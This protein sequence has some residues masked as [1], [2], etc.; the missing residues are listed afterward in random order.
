MKKRTS[1]KETV[2]I[3]RCGGDTAQGAAEAPGATGN[4]A[5]RKTTEEALRRE[6]DFLNRVMDTTPSGVVRVNR[7]GRVTYANRRAEEILG[8]TTSESKPRTY[9]DPRWNITDADGR[10][11]PRE[12][13]PFQVVRRT[14]RPVSGIRHAI[15]WPGGRR[16]LLSI[17]AAP[18]LDEG[19]GFDGMVAAMED[20]T[21]QHRREME[22]KFLSEQFAV[23]VQ[24]TTDGFWR[25]DEAGRLRDVNEAYCRMSGYSRS[26]LLEMT[27]MDLEA[28]ETEGETRQRMRKLVGEGADHFETCHRHK[29]GGTFYLEVSA[30]YWAEERQF[31]GFLR[32]I[33]ERKRAEVALRENE[34]RLRDALDAVSDGIWDLN[35]RTG[36]A[37]LNSR[38][39][40]MFG[41]PPDEPPPDS[42]GAFARVHPDDLP[43][44]QAALQNHVT[45]KAP[46][47][48][49]EFRVCR[50]DGRVR[51]LLGRGR[52]IEWDANGVPLRLIGTNTDVT[53]R[54]ESEA[55]LRAAL[56]AARRREIETRGLLDA[57]RAILE[58]DSFAEAARR[59]FDACREA[60]GGVS[61]YVAL[62]TE[63]GEENEVLFVESGGRP[64]DVDPDLPMP[65]R[66]LRAEACARREPVFDNDFMNSEWVR[67]MPEGHVRMEN[68]LFAPLILDGAVHGVMGLANKPGDFTPEDA[69][70]AGA[71][72]DMAAIALRRVRFE[73][74][75]RNSEAKYRAYVDHSPL[76]ILIADEAG[77]YVDVN[78]AAT[79]LFGYTREELLGM[80][81]TDLL[82]T[83]PGE[84][85]RTDFRRLKETGFIRVEKV[86]RRK[87][88]AR[89]DVYLEGVPLG[90]GRY[91]GFCSD[92]SDRKAAERALKKSEARVR[93]KL[94][95][96][97]TPEGELGDLDLADVLDVDAVQSLMDDFHR[98][99][100]IGVAIIDLSGKVLVATGWQEICTKF[101]RSHPET[102]AN[103]KESDL[104][105]SQ[106]IAADSFK[107]Y[108]C[109]NHMWD[110]ATPIMVGDRHLGNLFLGQ[111]FFEDEVPDYAVF[112][113]Q[114]RRY[115]F[116]EAAYIAALD[117][118]PRWSRER[119]H[120][121]MTFYAKFAGMVSSLSHGNIRLARTLS[122]RD[123]LLRDLRESEAKS[124]AIVD[125][126]DLG[127]ALIDPDMRVVEVNRRMREWFPEVA[128][129]DRPLCYQ[130]I[131]PI[132]RD[133]P[134]D[135]CPV[136]MALAD[137]QA[138]RAEMAADGPEGKR[139]FRVVAS[140]IFD[141][142]GRVTAAI[143]MMEDVTEQLLL[144][145][146]FRQAQKMEAIGQLTGGVAH[147]FNNLLQI[148]NGGTD[149]ALEDTETGH[150]ARESMAEVA[151]AG[152]RAAR[153]V[154]QLLLFSRRQIMRPADLELNAV[155]SDLLKMLGR[156][157]GEHIRIHWIPGSAPGAIHAD[158]GMIEQVLMNL[159]VNARDA[160]PD[161]G[162]LTIE[163]RIADIDADYCAHH[164]W[165]VP[166][167]YALLLVTDTGCGMD[168]ETLDRVFEPFFT[169]KGAG[170]G[171][172][173]GLATVYGIVKQHGG[174]ISGYSEPGVG[175]TFKVYLPSREA[176]AEPAGAE[177][178]R[179]GADGG[180]ET[181]LL[182]EDDEMVRK[183]ARTILERKGYRVWTAASGVEAL[184]RFQARPEAVD[185][186]ILDVMMPRMG[187]REAYERM[188][189]IRPAVKV[190]F[191]S[192]YSENAIHTN[193][194]L[195]DG[196]RLLQKPF[197][198]AELLR[199]VR[200]TL[201]E[202]P[203]SGAA[204]GD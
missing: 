189:E 69:R 118:V 153:L 176:E 174:M 120:T 116:D 166:G 167:R 74:A 61:G 165:A 169:T 179:P 15:E 57:A 126:V 132:A 138:H 137:A 111:F 195:H 146:Q 47:Y 26:E 19:G 121:V 188:R 70:I 128:P 191:A 49:R 71:F 112:R 124:R 53:E 42:D 123:R 25:V 177:N 154:S 35:V 63:S 108:R 8:L 48:S 65:V 85:P 122:E 130:A 58:C 75:L 152:Q 51:W 33:S 119:V 139:H 30:T 159:C 36:E 131:Q 89:V 115:G 142:A 97:L 186:A 156:V 200:Q 141:A 92:I 171:T 4:G 37:R 68:V 83:P 84:T 56:E 12:E 160:M 182:A 185:L 95:A 20:V 9:D 129:G 22:R 29:N 66:G 64:C 135:P 41:F 3:P 73:E 91:M 11:F 82:Y 109:K 86:F 183:M 158:R 87:D 13:L 106:G 163:T 110:M 180:T 136:R 90:N 50:P 77:R 107:L 60:T 134:C 197:A 148:I 6:R 76:A 175:T 59:I 193:Y 187:G 181:L 117:R 157:I 162:V 38:S 168:R 199:A 2:A 127:I 145:Q 196:P 105:F 192:G 72:G 43:G 45:G 143:E 40:E 184:E 5:A 103:C 155:V 133:A 98:L 151:A 46:F 14:G 194:V 101:H 125:N 7:D 164:V 81:I 94:D 190:V 16:V 147:D 55:R 99:T 144:E 114:A 88:G 21:E 79:A 172:G 1:W 67:F 201:D 204:R 178:G 17:N 78:A 93:K 24:T 100:N 54:A 113:E 18:L 104:E 150:P 23:M 62:L 34:K 80:D 52:A 198:P 28:S 202:A 170:K 96:I 149:L 32:D 10:P 203:D 102:A 39:A 27:V 31:I 140:P 161:G 173:L 44:I